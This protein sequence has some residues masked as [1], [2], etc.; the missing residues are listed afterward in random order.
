MYE[1]GRLEG[2]GRGKGPD[3]AVGSEPIAN[4]ALKIEISGVLNRD[5]VLRIDRIQP[6]ISGIKSS[7]DSY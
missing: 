4:K 6:L 1:N 2:G 7:I 5:T 3:K